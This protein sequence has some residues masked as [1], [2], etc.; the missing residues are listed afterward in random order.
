M[1]GVYVLHFDHVL[2][3]YK[4]SM[5]NSYGDPQHYVGIS[6]DVENRIMMHRIGRGSAKT[7]RMFQAGIFFS[8]TMLD[9]P[10]NIKNEQWVTKYVKDYCG[11]CL[12]LG[13]PD[14]ERAA[15][16]APPL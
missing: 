5:I 11:V 13:E 8:E 12:L 3:V 1:R 6:K 10:R 14:L 16:V 9:I 4:R 15:G 7:R 2:T